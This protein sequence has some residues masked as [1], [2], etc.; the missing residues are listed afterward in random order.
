ME[1]KTFFKNVNFR[2]FLILLGVILALYGAGRLYYRVTGGFMVS[3][4]TSTLPYDPR[5]DITPLTQAQEERIDALLSQPYRYLGK[6]CQSY[7]FSS[8]DG[9]YVI[10]FFKYQ[11]VR[12]QEWLKYFSAIPGVEA[13]R[14]RKIEKKKRELE[15]VFRSWIIAYEDLQPETGVAY[16]H[17]NKSKNLIDHMTIYDKMGFKHVLDPN[18]FEFMVQQKATMLCPAIDEM[19]AKGDE[20]GAKHLLDRLLDMILSEYARGMADN[21]HALMQNTGVIDG[22]PI[23]IDA[24]Q[25]I[26]NAIV[27]DPK[28]YHQELFS[29]T[30]KF[31]LWLKEHH[32][33][34]EA[35][36]NKRLREILGSQMD[37][38]KPEFNKARADRIPNA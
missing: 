32:P 7:V 37:T 5:W 23:H 11:R 25:F 22:Q 36:F 29:K 27:K 31:R 1:R 24:G 20:E 6:G 38:L 19:M 34:L 30:Y 28:V 14:Q 26:K 21:D 4:I 18:Q 3:N 2:R 8:E 13:Y 12:P 16:V 9:K 33:A 15:Y 35:H 10:K 17:L